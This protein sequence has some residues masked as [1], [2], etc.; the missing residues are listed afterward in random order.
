MQKIFGLMV[1]CGAIVFALL[2][3]PAC[4]ALIFRGEDLAVV[5]GILF[6]IGIFG[7]PL[8]A[9]WFFFLK[10]AGQTSAEGSGHKTAGSSEGSD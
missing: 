9:F 8:L 7:W 1:L 3:F 6:Y 10:D 2:I 5:R 4:N